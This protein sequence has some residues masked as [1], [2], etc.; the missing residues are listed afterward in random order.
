M[1]P[2]I[3]LLRCDNLFIYRQLQIEEA[4]LRNSDKN[5]CLFN[6]GSPLAIVMGISGRAPELLHL[7]RVAADRVPVIRRFSG[8]GTVVVD[9]N[10]LFASFILNRA[11]VGVKPLPHDV[12]AWARGLYQ[13]VFL[14]GNFQLRENDYVFGEK[15]FGGNAQYLCK[16]RWLHHT[17]FLWEYEIEKMKYLKIPSKAPQ[18][19][20]GREH[21]EFLCKI[22][23][24]LPSKD[25]FFERLLAQLRMF[26]DVKTVGLQEIAPL[27]EGDHRKA[28]TD[29]TAEH[30]SLSSI[31]QM[32]SL[33]REDS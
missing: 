24:W 2:Y 14:E 32:K 6:S 26:F 28:T 18:Y 17:S 21:G 12:H 5:W 22:N 4:L 10:T 15:K 33:A 29:I 31:V 9:E 3:H 7:D 25:I 27:L 11:A 13:N 16:E 19:R 20:A 30:A 23:R 1:K 8:G